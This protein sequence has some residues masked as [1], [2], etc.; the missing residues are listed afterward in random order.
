MI[1]ENS[2]IYRG[3]SL[4]SQLEGMSEIW[5]RKSLSNGYIPGDTCL[6]ELNVTEPFFLCTKQIVLAEKLS[7]AIVTIFLFFVFADQLLLV[8][9]FSQLYYPLYYL[10][11]DAKKTTIADF[12]INR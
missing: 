3:I 2:E 9:V 7:R 8:D 10:T 11:H 6:R 5:T 1:T 4:Q 12:V